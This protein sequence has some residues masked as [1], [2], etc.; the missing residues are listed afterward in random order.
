MYVCAHWDMSN[1]T[2]QHRP[3]LEP[4]D[5]AA[6]DERGE[7]P[8]S[9]PEG[10]PDGA[11]GQDDMEVVLAAADK[12]VEQSKRGEVC[13]LALSLS[14]GPHGLGEEIGIEGGAGRG[15]CV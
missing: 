8:Q 2:R 13:I 12:E 10:V 1:G 11:H 14:D 3:H 9:V 5:G 4:V 15:E 7:L 6:V